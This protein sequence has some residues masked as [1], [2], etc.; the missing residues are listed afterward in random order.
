MMSRRGLAGRF[1]ARPVGHATGTRVRVAARPGPQNHR[2]G[3]SAG[4]LRTGSIPPPPSPPTGVEVHQERA[5]CGLPAC[6]EPKEKRKEKNSRQGCMRRTWGGTPAMS[7][8]ASSSRR[9]L[10]FTSYS[11]SDRSSR[12]STSTW[13]GEREGRNGDERVAKPRKG[14]QRSPRISTSTCV[15]G[16]G[17]GGREKKGDQSLSKISAGRGGL[18]GNLQRR[19]AGKGHL[20]DG[21]NGGPPPQTLT[22]H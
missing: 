8:M 14:D 1:P 19:R 3:C 20:G 16:G 7:S 13:T 11:P 22:L 10:S 15:E 18:G 4:Q 6:Q 2:R 17:R 12:I 9:W 5:T 21:H